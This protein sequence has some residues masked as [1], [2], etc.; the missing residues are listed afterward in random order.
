M[1]A[2]ALAAGADDVVIVVR[3]ELA[4]TVEREVRR[5]FGDGLSLRLVAQDLADAPPRDRPWGTAH[6]VLVAT[7]GL[8]RPFVVVNADDY[9]GPGSYRRAAE[10]L[11]AG[12]GRTAVLVA[13]EAG[14]TLPP[15]GAVSRGVCTVR[16]RR[17][18]EIAET[19]GIERGA[20]GVIRSADPVGVLA[21]DTPVSM[22]M[23]G[24]PAAFAAEFG[25]RWREFLAAHGGDATTEFLLPDVIAGAVAEGRLEVVVERS[26]DDWIGVTN[27]DDLEPARAR[28]AVARGASMPGRAGPPR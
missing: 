2:D 18:V 16:D 4:D 24:F 7:E 8:D 1:V 17:L 27:P 11:G 6:A 25:P 9:Y 5:R 15:S 23:W 14:R 20:D 19:H 21:E 22:N 28:L 12:D 3:S 10:V 26:G 13:F